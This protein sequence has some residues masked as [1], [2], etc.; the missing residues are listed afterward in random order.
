VTIR[1]GWESDANGDTFTYEDKA[2]VQIMY[3]GFWKVHVPPGT[4]AESYHPTLEQA[5]LRAEELLDPPK[6]EDYAAGFKDG[7][8]A[9]IRLLTA[10]RN[11]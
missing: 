7:I 2:A 1:Q 5:M 10:W 11:Q 4:L 8:D 6:N 9:C 3:G